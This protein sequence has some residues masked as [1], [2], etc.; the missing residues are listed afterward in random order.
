[1]KLAGLLYTLTALY[2]AGYS[3]E[4]L[5]SEDFSSIELESCWI[6]YGDPHPGILDSLGIPPPCFINNG[7]SMYGSGV[8]SRTVYAIGEGLGVACD[9]YLE[10][11]ER[12][13]WVTAAL[14]ITTP[15]Y[16][17]EITR[18]N[19][20]IAR[21]E[22]FYSGE[23]DWAMP[24]RQCVLKFNTGNNEGVIYSI[25]QHHQNNLLSS[26]H[27][28]RIEIDSD[29]MVSFFIDD[30]LVGSSQVMIPDTVETVRI[31]LGDRS[32]NWG[33]ALHDNLVVYR[34]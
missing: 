28:Y 16:R 13:T 8:F 5:F 26:W 29:R 34:P 33:I 31:H 15:G 32:S 10:C 25:E 9:M 23:L 1:M 2:A 14:G 6:L 7:D 19:F 11:R 18:N 17:N 30:S 4:V 22:I 24:H 20:S 27:N 21:M 12:G 3:G